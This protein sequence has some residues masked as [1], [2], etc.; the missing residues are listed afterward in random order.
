MAVGNRSY[1]TVT[2]KGYSPGIVKLGRW[3]WVTFS[4]CVLF[5]VVAV[6]LPFAQLLVG[7]FFR[8]FDS[9]TGTC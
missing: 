6:A 7:S 3:R 1:Q 2:G 5:F 8:L 9:T 4:I